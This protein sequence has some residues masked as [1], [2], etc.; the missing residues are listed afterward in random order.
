MLILHKVLELLLSALWECA[1][2]YY[3]SVGSVIRP[4]WLSSI[5]CLP[6]PSPLLI[7]YILCLVPRKPELDLILP[8]AFASPK[9][10]HLVLVKML[11]CGSS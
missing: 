2:C 3:D 10:S 8:G 5:M 7:Y 9:P 6:L 4:A 11:F 1:N